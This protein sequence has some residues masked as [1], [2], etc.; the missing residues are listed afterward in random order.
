MMVAW[1]QVH[2]LIKAHI[3]VLPKGFNPKLVTRCDGLTALNKAGQQK[4]KHQG[5]MQTY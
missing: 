1:Y 2:L 4:T 5:H 3:V